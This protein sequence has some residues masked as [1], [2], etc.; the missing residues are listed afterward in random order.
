[1]NAKREH[2]LKMLDSLTDNLLLQGWVLPDN[3]ADKDARQNL[4]DEQIM[5]LLSVLRFLVRILT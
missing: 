3:L 1:M 4:T 5:L 2:N